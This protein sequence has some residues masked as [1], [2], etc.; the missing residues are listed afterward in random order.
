MQYFLSSFLFMKQVCSVEGKELVYIEYLFQDNNQL[1]LSLRPLSSFLEQ[2]SF[3]FVSERK[4]FAC[5]LSF[6]TFYYTSIIVT[7]MMPMKMMLL[8]EE[9]KCHRSRSTKN[10]DEAYV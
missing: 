7:E 9:E 10:H 8:P 3:L 6:F 1:F 4:E 5:L 2:F